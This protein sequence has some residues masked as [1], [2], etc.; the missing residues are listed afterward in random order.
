MHLN[1]KS[2]YWDSYVHLIITDLIIFIKWNR[3]QL[4]S[5][6]SQQ[7][8]HKFSQKTSQ[9]D[10][11]S[12]SKTPQES[13]QPR[14]IKWARWCYLWDTC[15]L[16]SFAQLWGEY[17]ATIRY[18]ISFLL[19]LRPSPVNPRSM[20]ILI[21]SFWSLRSILWRNQDLGQLHDFPHLMDYG[22]AYP[23]PIDNYLESSACIIWAYIRGDGEIVW[24]LDH[25]IA[26]AV[27]L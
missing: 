7:N 16:A 18:G 5:H 23:D 24:V 13:T 17:G 22:F 8:Y 19:I 27:E 26:K 10:H 11:K 21:D 4:S 6:I 12:I 25:E 15:I 2:C 14:H 20:L 3:T 9:K 1:I